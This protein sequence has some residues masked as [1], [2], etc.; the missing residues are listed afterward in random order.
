MS[1]IPL[2][3]R[4][5][6][7]ESLPT[8]LPS[9]PAF[10]EGDILRAEQLQAL[11]DHIRYLHL[12][13]LDLAGRVEKLET[14]ERRRWATAL[15]FSPTVLPYLASAAGA[16]QVGWP[17]RL[18]ATFS[19]GAAEDITHDSTAL[20]ELAGDAGRFL[21]LSREQAMLWPLLP[22]V[23]NLRVSYGGLDVSVPVT[24]I[25]VAQGGRPT[26]LYQGKG[27]ARTLSAD[28]A[29]NVWPAAEF[30]RLANE[31][32]PNQAL[33]HALYSAE[34]PPDA[35]EQHFGVRLLDQLHGKPGE[36][37]CF[38]L[39]VRRPFNAPEPL[40]VSVSGAEL[41]TNPEARLPPGPSGNR[42]VDL[43]IVGWSGRATALVL[44][45]PPVVGIREVPL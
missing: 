17:C 1:W 14:K 24:V 45:G 16:A 44:H 12:R 36:R 40:R 15:R 13:L 25:D 31:G 42:L 28:I 6:M 43:V 39:F 34:P 26:P 30:T 23:G 20:I 9:L 32:A 38:V 3:S 2:F 11:S 8:S 10:R 22:G 21:R 29:A 27:A 4:A 5:V 33:V 19:D 7:S 41:F 37:R 35:V 18:M